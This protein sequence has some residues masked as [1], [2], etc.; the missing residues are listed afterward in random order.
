MHPRPL[1][2]TALLS[3]I[4]SPGLLFA[5]HTIPGLLLKRATARATAHTD[6]SAA[7]T[8]ELRGNAPTM[9]S[10]LF[11]KWL[12]PTIQQPALTVWSERSEARAVGLRALKKLLGEHF[13]GETT[14]LQA[15]G[16]AKAAAIIANSLPTEKR[17]RSGDLGELLATEYVSAETAFVVPIKK[18]RWKS[19]R[20]MPMHGNDLVAV[21]VSTKPVS[22]LK[23]ECKSRSNLGSAVI[24]EAADGLDKNDGRPNPS[25]LAF[26]TKRLY[27]DQRDDEA[28]VYR[29][30]QC[31]GAITPKQMTHLVFGLCGNDPTIHLSA[32]P[33]PQCAGIK[34]DAAAVVIADH[35]AFVAKV[36]S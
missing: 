24:K 10:A 14:I 27:E 22:V 19:D 5:L 6:E 29:D 36:F 35:G 33:K 9:P 28:E 12:Q 21:D 34:R 11:T 32:T 18:L 26:I 16:Y 17:T 7:A 3:A 8:S 25:T 30:L 1:S 31:K 4:S 2:P 13:V 23:G 15:G 20:Q